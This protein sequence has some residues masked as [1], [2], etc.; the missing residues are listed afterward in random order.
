[1]K[2]NLGVVEFWRIILKNEEFVSMGEFKKQF[3]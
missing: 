2:G 3:A 1:M